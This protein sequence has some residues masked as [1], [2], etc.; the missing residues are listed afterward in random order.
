MLFRKIILLI[1]ILFASLIA[2]FLLRTS[3]KALNSKVLTPTYSSSGNT[4][5]IKFLYQL[6]NRILQVGKYL[7]WR[8]MCYEQALTARII[9]NRR[10]QSNQLYIGFKDE[11]GKRKIHAWLNSQDIT[12]TGFRRMEEYHVINSFH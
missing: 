7:P 3:F 10:R 9:L 5:S 1:E 12:L 4:V 6:S 2:S 11:D 8:F